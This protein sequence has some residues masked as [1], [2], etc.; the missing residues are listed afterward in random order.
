[1]KKELICGNV[2]TFSN[3]VPRVDPPPSYFFVFNTHATFY[4]RLVISPS[5]VPEHTEN[6]SYNRGHKSF[7]PPPSQLQLLAVS[8]LMAGAL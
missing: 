4:S 8:E 3:V 7:S 1:M 5:L 6:F 2:T